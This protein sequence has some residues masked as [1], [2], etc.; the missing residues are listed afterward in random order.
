MAILHGWQYCPRCRTELDR[1][2][3]SVRCP[4]CGFTAYANSVPTASAL[5]EDDAGRLL[6]AR[7]AVDP[8]VGLWDVPGGYLEEGEHPLEGLVR[9]LRE[10]AGVEIQPGDLFGIWMDA[11]GD[12]DDANATLNLYWPARIASGEIAAADDV[13]ELRWF[14]RDELPPPSELAFRS[15]ADVLAAWRRRR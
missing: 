6:L 2:E 13:A 7:R 3:G 12:G 11:Y 5:V 9:E 4:G 1:A 10:E 15:T 8:G 14:G